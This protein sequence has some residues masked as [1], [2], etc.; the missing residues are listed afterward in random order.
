MG[1][2]FGLLITTTALLTSSIPVHSQDGSGTV[3]QIPFSTTTQSPAST[4]YSTERYGDLVSR[5]KPVLIY[6]PDATCT[7]GNITLA[8]SE[9]QIYVGTDITYQCVPTCSRTY[10][11]QHDTLF[12]AVAEGMCIK[13]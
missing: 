9:S 8:A 12:Q 13:V 1:I 7:Q 11:V 3:P 2:W 5:Y 10:P 4:T 6:P